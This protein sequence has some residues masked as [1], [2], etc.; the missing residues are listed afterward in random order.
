MS[1]YKIENVRNIGIAAHIDAGKTTIT[2]RILYYTGKSY[3]IG[4][5]H[6]GNAVM[7]WMAQEQERGITITSAATTCHWQDSI[8][9]IIDTPGHVDF[10]VEVERS[11]RVLDG[12]VGVFCAVAGVQPQSE[13]V[14]RQAKKYDV[15]VVAFI[16]KMDRVGADF[17]N[18]VRMIKEN[19]AASPVVVCYPLGSESQFKGV[20]DIINEKEYWYFDEEL[21]SKYEVKEV[22]EDN[23]ELVRDLREKLLE[24]VAETTDA[25]LEEYLEKGTL[26]IAQVKA[27]LRALTIKGDIVP[28][29]CGSAFKNKGI[30]SLLDGVVD[31]LPSPVDL[32]PVVGCSSKA[33]VEEA[34]KASE[35][36]SFSALA[37]KVQTDPF[38]GKLTY[39]RLYSGKLTVGSYAYNSTKNK[40]ERISRILQMHAN[41]RNELKEA[42]AGDIVAVIGLKYTKTGDTL[43]AADKPIIL[44]NIDFPEPVIF[45]AI[46]PKTKID[47]DRLSNSLEKLSEEDPTFC[48]KT[49]IETSQTIISGMGELH[50]EIIVDR[51]KREFNVQAN[52]GKPQVAYKETIRSKSRAEGKFI[53]QS[54]GRGQ[55]G[56]VILEVEP[57]D[58]GGGF[59]FVNKVVGGNIPREY[60]PSVEKGVKEAFLTGVMAGFPVVDIK[61]TLLDGSYHAVDSSDIA[62]QVAAS[63]AVKEAFK[64]GAAAILEPIMAVEVDV[65]EVNMGD[66]IS[67]INSRRGKIDKIAV[68]KVNTQNIKSHV[69]LA[70]MFE[71]S[72]TLRSLT[73][74]RGIYSMQFFGYSEVP[75]QIYENIVLEKK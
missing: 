32:P 29:Y 39:L 69:P 23:L 31:F 17:E 56:H 73:Q 50:L 41:T 16:N 1:K 30:Q 66:V 54:G 35:E 21:G 38:V 64:K 68:T 22:S 2:E 36:E 48:Y 42:K 8:I 53:K 65:P 71:F 14:W 25:Y 75:K 57:L 9:N 12:M 33:G 24:T 61:V 20:I 51:L 19:L 40:K 49:D 70:E 11:L 28:I 67:N 55:Y 34:R 26:S 44:E 10:T 18:A 47:Q 45:V 52:V 62:F 15:P 46:E 58:R 3:K 43:C 7:D 63:Y 60:I 27:G 37:F 13:T 74:G 5:V 59:E 72:T 6:D 4:E